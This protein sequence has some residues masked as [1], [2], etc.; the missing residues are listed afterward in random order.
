MSLYY[1]MKNESDER[2]HSLDEESQEVGTGGSAC[3]LCG[4]Q[5]A[6]IYICEFC[7]L[8]VCGC[9]VGLCEGCGSFVCAECAFVATDDEIDPCCPDC[10]IRQARPGPSPE[11]SGCF[12]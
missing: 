3:S 7:K 9:C 8:D 10:A 6:E 11:L 1:L 5:E 4:D 12:V 2:I